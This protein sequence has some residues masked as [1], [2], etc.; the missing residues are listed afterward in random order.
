[1]VGK[2]LANGFSKHGYEV[3]LGTSDTNKYEE[4]KNFT[5]GNVQIGTF[6][7]TSKFGEIIV[8]AV[9]GTSVEKVLQ[10]AGAE[11][12]KNKT[13]I[14]TTN[15]LADA[16]PIHGVLHFYTKSNSSL[17]EH[18]QQLLPNAN[19][20]KA[21]SCVGYSLMVNPSFNGFRPTMFICGNNTTAKDDVKTI[22]EQFGWDVEDMGEIEAARAIEPLS[23]LYCIPGLRENS[24]QHAF[25]LLKK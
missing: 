10:L 3:M 7:Q 15:P 4:L 1:M 12:F 9:K 24:W 16:A 20:V 2:T 5:G 14:D 21:F 25:K 8:F 18:L 23:I 22:L 11:N 13:V 17:M 6:E 19:F